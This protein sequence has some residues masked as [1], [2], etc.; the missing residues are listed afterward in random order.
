MTVRRSGLVST[1]RFTMTGPTTLLR[2]PITDA[3]VPNVY[4]QVDLVGKAKRVGDDGKPRTDLPERPA[5]GV[6]LINLPVPPKKRTL[7]VEVKPRAD[8]VEPGQKAQFDVTVKDADG[9]GVADAE[10]AL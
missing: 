9:K 7:A 1:E 2:I 8:K 3:Y 5:Y 6:G 10:V 4:V